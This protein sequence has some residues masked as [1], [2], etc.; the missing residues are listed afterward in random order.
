MFH[1]RGQELELFSRF[2]DKLLK[3]N[4]EFLY[5]HDIRDAWDNFEAK[6]INNKL[7]D[8]IAQRDVMLFM[9]NDKELK[10]SVIELHNKRKVTEHAKHLMQNIHDHKKINEL[11]RQFDIAS[12]T[13]V[14]KVDNGIIAQQELEH[15]FKVADGLVPSALETGT[16]LDRIDGGFREEYILLAARPS[17]GKSVMGLQISINLARQGKKVC[18]FSLEMSRRALIQRYLYHMSKVSAN[19]AK[20]KILSQQQRVQLIKAAD[21]I[22]S[23]PID[24]ID[25]KCDV[26]D[27][28]EKCTQE[29]YDAVV[30]DY[31]QRIKPHRSAT[32]REVVEEISH[33][34]SELPKVIRAPVITIASLSR[35]HDKA[36]NQRPR[37]NELKETSNLEYD[38]DVIILLHRENPD[39]QYLEDC[40]AICTK[41]R[42]GETGA[43]MMKIRGSVYRFD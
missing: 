26:F 7:F 27:I 14:E 42:N 5:C 38:A 6:G 4:T 32:R 20:N 31:L 28:V 39:G 1:N 40:E 21:E 22:S 23:L 34:L 30:I 25:T 18:Y 9:M 10:R 15:I 35:P 8:E 13:E 29:K 11:V 16:P 41:N 2:I 3:F 24:V 19:N 17:V 36:S 33:E 37:M 43:T 12:T